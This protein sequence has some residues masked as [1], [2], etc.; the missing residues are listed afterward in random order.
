M[1]ELLLKDEVVDRAPLANLEQAKTFFM[2][3]KQMTEEQF[4]EIG[5]SVRLVKPKQRK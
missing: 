1:Y 5:Y 2:K 3:R 4:N